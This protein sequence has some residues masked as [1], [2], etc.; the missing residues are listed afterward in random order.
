VRDTERRERRCLAADANDKHMNLIQSLLNTLKRRT[1][2]KSYEQQCIDAFLAALD[3]TIRSVLTEQLSSASVIQRQSG[4]AKLC[5]YY[6]EKAA[7][8]VLSNTSPDV[9]AATV[10]LGTDNL[11]K[12]KLMPVKVFV[13][14]GKFF[15]L[16]FP[17]RPT[18]FV[19]QH[20]MNLNNL[21]VIRVA[22]FAEL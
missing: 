21:H 5:F 4:G 11:D 16:E 22:I 15:S 20:R 1:V 17:K 2:L 14:R 7:I 10:T 13:H 6:P 12:D 9:H 8:P 19:E 18:R 3:P